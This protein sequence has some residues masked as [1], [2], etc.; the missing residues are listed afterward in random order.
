MEF[1]AN[2]F[3]NLEELIVTHHSESCC[4]MDARLH[5]LYKSLLG[6]G[7]NVVATGEDCREHHLYLATPDESLLKKP[8]DPPYWS[9]Y[10]EG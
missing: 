7:V 4:I 2:F 3:P 1:I 10:Q 8:L 5:I 6:R 9:S